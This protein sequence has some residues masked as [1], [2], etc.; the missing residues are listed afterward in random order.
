MQIESAMMQKSELMQKQNGYR[1]EDA[2]M[3]NP[4]VAKKVIYS[5]R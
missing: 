3:K 1:M 5:Y 4:I 2:F